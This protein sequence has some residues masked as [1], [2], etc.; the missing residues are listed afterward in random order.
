M[1]ERPGDEGRGSKVLL[2]NEA[3][4]ARYNALAKEY[5]TNYP[6][7]VSNEEAGKIC[8]SFEIC[9]MMERTSTGIVKIGYDNIS[10]NDNFDSKKN[11]S[12]MF[13]ETTWELL[14]EWFVENRSSLKEYEELRTWTEI[15]KE[16]GGTY[17]RIWPEENF[18]KEL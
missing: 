6:N 3:D 11:W 15:L 5:Y 1:T 13:S 17:E 7:L 14:K 8:A 12:I 9:G 4:V 2:Q 18:G 10:Y 16:V